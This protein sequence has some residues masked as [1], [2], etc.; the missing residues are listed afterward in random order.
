M[1]YDHVVG[2]DADW[3]ERGD[4]MLARHGIHPGWANEALDDPERIVIVPDPASKSGRGVRTI[5]WSPT[6]NRIITVITLVDEGHLYGVNGWVANSGDQRLY[7]REER[8][9]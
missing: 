1:S 8:D 3:S 4:Y 2:I 9:E 5:G 7:R 6:A